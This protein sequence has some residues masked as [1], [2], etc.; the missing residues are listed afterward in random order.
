MM[1]EFSN[2]IGYSWEKTAGIPG[3]FWAKIERKDFCRYS[4]ATKYNFVSKECTP[5][6]LGWVLWLSFI[7]LTGVFSRVVSFDI[8]CKRTIEALKSMIQFYVITI[9]SEKKEW[10]QVI[11]SQ[12]NPLYQ[13]NKFN[14]IKTSL[15][16]G[17]TLVV[18][19]SSWKVW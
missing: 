15:D 18:D 2:S 5:Q 16:L 12:L 11:I 17:K 10:V 13:L 1:M 8:V 14:L 6:Q 7:N 4:S 9:H 3:S 19:D